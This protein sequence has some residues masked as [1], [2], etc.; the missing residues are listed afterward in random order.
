MSAVLRR[1]VL[2]TI[3][4]WFEGTDVLLTRLGARKLKKQLLEK[5]TDR[6]VEL[7]LRA[8]SLSFYLLKKDVD[9]QN[10][11]R[12]SE[13]RYFGGRYL[14]QTTKEDAIIASAVFANGD[15]RVRKDAIS[16]WDVK[17][18]FTDGKALRK[19]LFSEDQDIINSLAENEVEVEGNLNYIYKFGF[20]AK[21][22]LQRL[23]V[24]L[25]D[26]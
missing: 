1:F 3:S 26:V 18:T 4:N 12:D 2:R 23:N 11:L 13:G 24:V 17:V 16:E 9:Y 10:H 21:D 7:L 19:F 25:G 15:M 14:F 6:L 20:M 22:L 5:T 8:M